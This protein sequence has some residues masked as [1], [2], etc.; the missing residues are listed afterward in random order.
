MIRIVL[1]M[2]KKEF[3]QL[4]RTPAMLAILL[5]CPIVSVGLV[6]FG[7]GNKTLM[8]LEVVAPAPSDQG[9]QTVLRLA[10]SPHVKN[11]SLA[12]ST[13]DVFEHLNKGSIDAALIIQQ[14]NRP[15][16]IFADGTN[17][18]QAA[19]ISYYLNN[20]LGETVDLPVEI[21][22]HM[23]FT[24]KGDNTHYYIIAMIVLLLAIVGPVLICLSYVNER[25]RKMLEHLRS[26]GLKPSTYV[27]SKTAFYV[28]LSLAE[29][30]VALIL[31]K[32]IFNFH[33]YGSLLLVYLVF[34]LFSFAMVGVGM[35]VAAYSKTLVQAIYIMVF[36]YLTLILLGSMFAP[37]DYLSDAWAMTRYFN[38][39]YWSIDG[40]AKVILKDYPFKWIASD[41]AIL[42]TI[43][44]ILSIMCI[45]RV[46]R[47]D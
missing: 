14:D 4:L 16:A 5:V 24:S 6:P 8:R 47:V 28:V 7:L 17:I 20:I 2:M 43:G 1:Q 41:C 32:T 12:L 34:G 37:L 40:A 19:N 23:L 45:Q 38:P 15:S 9:Q 39:F 46:K 3:L 18:L 36:L 13:N 22:E 25:D 11:V 29:L 10:R 26:T 27:L 35:A 31:G 44:G 30:T 42:A 33:C 21:R